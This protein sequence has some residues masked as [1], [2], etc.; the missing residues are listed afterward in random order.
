LR[1]LPI[2]ADLQAE[3]DAKYSDQNYDLDELLNWEYDIV[4][5]TKI[6]PDFIGAKAGAIGSKKHRGMLQLNEYEQDRFRHVRDLGHTNDVLEKALRR[7]PIRKPFDLHDA[8]FW[9]QHY[10]IV[11]APAGN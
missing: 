11:D 4:D 6:Q 10:L 8:A 2:D 3:L 7:F 9:S 1:E 5:S